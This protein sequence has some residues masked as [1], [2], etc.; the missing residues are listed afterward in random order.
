MMHRPIAFAAA[1][2]VLSFAS[3]LPP[4]PAHAAVGDASAGHFPTHEGLEAAVEFWTSIYAT[5]TT[6]HVV[7]HDNRH[8]DVVYGVLDFTPYVKGRTE[9]ELESLIRETTER[10]KERIATVLLELDSYKEGIP[11]SRLTDEERR[12]HSLFTNVDE[13]D[14]YR[15]ASA[16]LRGQRGQAD[17]FLHGIAE[18]APYMPTFEEIFRKKGLP[19]DLTRLTFVESMFN[20]HAYSKVGAAGPWQFMSY[21]GKRFLTISPE[22]D[23]RLDPMKST[24]AAASLLKENYAHLGDW[25][26]ALTAYNHGVAGMK[27]AVAA[28]GTTDIGQI[29]W[30]YQSRSF[31]F[32]SRNF[33]AEFVAA[34]DVYNNRE[35]YFGADVIASLP[36]KHIEPYDQLLLPDF[37][38][39][40]TLEKYC[41]VT[42][43]ELKRL[44]PSLTRYVL[45]GQKYLPKG[46]PLK[47]PA[48]KGK[49]VVKG[50]A[51]IPATAR[52]VAQKPS[53]FHVVRRGE[54]LASIARRYGMSVDGL[55]DLNSLSSRNRI[56]A[57]QRLRVLS[58]TKSRA[59]ATSTVKKPEVKVLPVVKLPEDAAASAASVLS[60]AVTAPEPDPVSDSES[61][62][63]LP[64]AELPEDQE[65]LLA[66]AEAPAVE[67]PA[68]NGGALTLSELAREPAPPA[69]ASVVLPPAAD[70]ASARNLAVAALAASPDGV[71][72]PVSTALEPI[73]EAVRPARAPV[74]PPRFRTDA[75]AGNGGAVYP[76]GIRCTLTGH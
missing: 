4:R 37:V 43:E 12:I 50:Y 20:L 70:P 63:E 69:S 54:N 19:T 67:E 6:K 29:A 27:R 61:E 36:V 8:L 38:A 35:T 25:G 59:V 72:E 5:Y 39:V 64:I 14:K 75:R 21:T 22:V 32:A 53:E 1:L 66:A 73:A 46:Y 42:T 10:E 24:E 57:G 7:L 26:L 11:F 56:R 74:P 33:Y 49:Q 45:S 68:A 18:V 15:A 41:G 34:R 31:G 47:V 9:K 28:S 13:I 44:N 52:F 17:R 62:V 51:S 3:A 71:A 58:P 16:R 30:T 76:G 65:E 2:A 23:E 48:G 55:V 40:G 60:A